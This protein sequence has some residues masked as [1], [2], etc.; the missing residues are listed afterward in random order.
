MNAKLN[1]RALSSY[2][3]EKRLKIMKEKILPTKWRYQFFKQ[4]GLILKIGQ[5]IRL[6]IIMF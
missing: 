6:Q 5:K 4:L 2:E 1:E 3:I